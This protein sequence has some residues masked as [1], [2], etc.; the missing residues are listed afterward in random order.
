MVPDATPENKEVYETYKKIM[1]NIHIGQ[2][3]GL[4]LP[5]FRDEIKGDKLFEFEIVNSTGQKAYDISGI[6]NRLNK[7]IYTALYA[8]FLILGQEGGGSFA[9]SESKQSLVQIIIRSKL[10]EI[11]DVLNHHLVPLL[12]KYNGWETE[13]YP[14]FEFG[15]AEEVS[16]AEFAKAT[17]QLLAAG[18]IQISAKNINHIADRLGLPDRFDESMTVDKVREELSGN[19]TRASDGFTTT[20]DGTSKSPSGKDSSAS[21]AANK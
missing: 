18:G 21:N 15:E 17:Y 2:E 7:E 4:I 13:V 3:S 16:L 9:L 20:G 12:F 14:T 6:I 19:Q 1:R 10:E 8:D 5:M 11:R